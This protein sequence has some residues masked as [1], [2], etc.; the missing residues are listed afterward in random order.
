MVKYI[1]KNFILE[2]FPQRPENSH[3]GTFGK[4]LNVAGSKAYVGAAYLSSISALKIGAGYVSLALPSELITTISVMAPEITFIPLISDDYGAISYNNK[5]TNITDFD[6]VSI[7]CG[8]T[9]SNGTSDFV[10]GLMKN[11]DSPSK[12]V[13]DADCIN[14]L[15]LSDI[16]FSLKNSII[17]P[18]PKEL[19]R[20]LKV[21]LDDIIEN[22]EKYVMITSQK[23]ECITVLKG[24][25]T[26]ISD[27]NDIYVNSTGSSALAKA[28]TGDVLTGMISGLLAQKLNN[29]DA[30]ICAVYLHGLSGDIAAESLTKYSVLASDVVDCIPYAIDEL[31]FED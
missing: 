12:L 6:V 3:K 15:S 1:D 10:L 7:G 21:S 9:T 16:N 30:A 20:L 13:I 26:V 22:R 4:I 11:I 18:H 25:N 14:I 23:F 31:L 8:I 19:S 17:T 24:H 27:G 2:K 29:L 5:I 28:G